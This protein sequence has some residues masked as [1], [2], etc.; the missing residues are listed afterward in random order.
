MT[1]SDLRLAIDVGGTF[2][3]VVVRGPGSGWAAHK[4][5]STPDDPSRGVADALAAAARGQGLEVGELLARTTGFVHGTTITTNALL[6]RTGARTALLTT[7][8]LAD[9]LLLRQGRRRLRYAGATPQPGALVPR[10]RI[11]GI[12]ERV[13]RDGQVTTP[14]D[15]AAV[16]AVARRLRDEAVEAVAV[17][18]MFS[19]LDDRHERRVAELL[20]EELPA[21]FV[22]L[23]SALSP[24]VGLYE[25]TSTAV[26]DAYVGP[27]LRR[28]LTALRDRLA[29]LGFDGS[30]LIMQSNGGLAAPEVVAARPVTT[31][32]SGP[33]GG[34]VAGAGAAVAVGVPRAITADM[35]G[36]SFEV[37]FS[38]GGRTEVRGEGEVDG[39]LVGAPML[40]I[41]TIGSGGGSI[42]TATEGGALQVGPASAGADPGPACY[43]RG[44]T[45]P[46]VTDASLVLGYLSGAAL[47][48][49]APLR[50][51]LAE[52]AIARLGARLGL[53]ALACAAGIHRTVNAAMAD[54]VRVELATRGWDPRG[55]ALVIGGGAGPLHG[56]AIAR[57]LAIPLV[58]LSR[59]A[60]VLC[61]AG[62]LASDIV[63]HATRPVHGRAGAADVAALQ[64]A[65]VALER[66]A[67][68]ELARE[69][70][71]AARRSVRR[72]LELRSI[73]QVRQLEV[74]LPPGE[75]VS[76]SVLA[77]AHAAFHAAHRARFGYA[78]EDAPVEV[79]DLRLEARGTVAAPAAPAPDPAPPARP[80]S[81]PPPASRVAWFD[82]V[83]LDA[84]VVAGDGL[85][86]GD[87]VVGPA[88]VQDATSTI[89]VP[90]GMAL[91]VADGGQQLL[92]HAAGTAV[93][94]IL[95][96]LRQEPARA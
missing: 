8:G 47:S 16:R 73:G 52:A 41:A 58:V 80:G 14:L 26:V 59:E 1:P 75:P 96:R 34:P 37:S 19:W 13:D 90:P 53:D 45:E 7:A 25:R 83:A 32:L 95:E 10:W 30:L 35:G 48:G 33:A 63:H 94:E 51:D 6:T 3:D 87:V 71:P 78:L 64:A 93:G 85:G 66:A 68:A 54:R 15:E 24:R 28:Y 70:V 84:A 61:A 5:P 29:T 43:G 62:M 11:H 36:T 74:A 42:A 69:G 44:G 50:A 76:P 77:T 92:L 18:L 31:L 89:V 21:A 56:A 60:P 57:A 12:A 9:L 79:V 81:A 55:F 4:V 72:S 27:A 2:T 22:T 17:A 82:G 39:Q 20:A 91:S 67:D 40:D 86:A 65:F 88:L 23:S 49:G 38:H 46:T